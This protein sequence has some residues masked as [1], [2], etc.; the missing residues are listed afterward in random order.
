MTADKVV[1]EAES[2]ADIYVVLRG[3][4]EAYMRNKD[5]RTLAQLSD[6]DVF[7]EELFI[8]SEYN[9]SGY[10]RH[11]YVTMGLKV[12]ENA[13]LLIIPRASFEEAIYEAMRNELF[14]KLYF[15]R[16]CPLF[17]DIPTE[18]LINFASKLPMTL[19]R[20]CEVI[21][22]QGEVPKKCYIVANGICQSIFECIVTGSA[23]PSKYVRK[24]Q[25]SQPKA[26]RFGLT[27]FHTPYFHDRICPINGRENSYDASTFSYNNQ[28]VSKT[29]EGQLTY[30]SHVRNCLFHFSIIGRIRKARDRRLFRWTNFAQICACTEA[31]L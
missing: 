6:G 31:L 27:S 30:K 18:G 16:M 19:K 15:I 9:P 12:T 17:G 20:Y 22:K 1:I 10:S 28:V 24:S 25:K 5:T 21:L 4:V 8:E 23:Q 3:S 26:L 11:S 7:G 14:H 29:K 2:I 13:D